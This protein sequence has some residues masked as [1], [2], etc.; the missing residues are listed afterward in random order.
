MAR[1]R[2]WAVPG[3]IA[4]RGGT[5]GPH[6]SS[7][8]DGAFCCVGGM[9][10]T[11]YEPV[12]PSVDLPALE[13]EVLAFWRDAGVFE[14]SL[15]AREGS[16]EWVFYEGPPTAN[17]KPGIH[18]AESRTFKDLYPQYRTMTGHYVAR[19]AGWDCHGLPVELEVERE[20]GTKTKRD[21]EAFGIEE[22][23]R[24]CRASVTRYVED[25]ERLTE[26]LGFW[27]DMSQAYFTMSPEYIESVWWS[28][29]ELHRQ[30]LLYEAHRSVAYCPRCGTALSDHE[31]ALG[32]STVV[33]PSVYVKLPI[34][35]SPNRPD[36]VGSSLVIWT[37]T[38]WTLPSNI[39][40][41]VAPDQTYVRAEVDGQGLVVAERLVGPSLGEDA[42][43][44]ETFPGS[45]LVGVRYE[46][47]YPN[48]DGDVHRVVTGDFVGMDE[49]TGIVHIATGFGSEDLEVGR[50]EGW[51]IYRPVDD[52]GKFTD[53]APE[54]VRGRAVKETDEDITG[55]LERSG[56]LLRAERYEHT[57]P[58]CW[59]C[60]TPLLYMAR[61]SWYIRTTAKKDRLLEVNE[62]VGWYPEHVKHG[63]YGDWLEN[64]VDW[65]LSRERY[66]GT[67]LPVWRCGNGHVTVIGSLAELSERAGR[68]VGAVDPHRPAIDEVEIPCPECGETARRVPEVIDTWY[69]SGAMPYA[70]W[71][72]H[73]DLNR[74]LDEARA[75][76]PA[77]FISEGIDQTRGWF[78]SLMAE[79]VLLFDDA[80]YRNC[81]VLGLLLDKEGRKMSKRLGNVVDPWEVLDRYGADALRWFFIVAGS[82][83]SD[84]RVSNEGI[85]DGVRRLLLTVW[86]VYA[87]YV[88]YANADDVDPATGDATDPP[89]LDRWILSRL[90]GTVAAARAGLD[91]YDATGAGR[92]IAGFVDDLSNWYVRLARRRFRGP[93][94]TPSSDAPSAH[95]TLYECLTT[96]CRLLA[97]FTPFIADAMWRNL[98]REGPESVHLADYP[99]A[100][101]VDRDER[102]EAAMESARRIVSLGRTVRTEAGVRVR[103]PLRR[104][105]VHAGGD[106]KVLE[107]LLGL[108]AEELNV[109][110]VSVVESAETLA[111]WRAIPNYRA[112]GP[113]LGKAVQEVARMLDGNEQAAAALARGERVELVTSSG[114]VEVGPEDVELERESVGGW[115]V[116]AEGGLTVGLDLEITPELARDGMARELVRF[117]QDARKAAGLD[118]A[119]RI[120]LGVTA[121]GPIA[122]AVDERAE[123]IAGEVLARR[124]VRGSL[125]GAEHRE[126]RTIDGHTAVVELRRAAG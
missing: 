27:I 2:E 40:A 69:D 65:A 17:G 35:E 14:K 80:A 6:A 44:G 33:D 90:A 103:Q 21:I 88:T 122:E 60:D 3:G 92:Q 68:D 110:E 111:G 1:D 108:V 107:P 117:I 114:E 74:G 125:D 49:G 18:H 59:R 52:D 24:R 78:Y 112:L 73:P 121:G 56:R 106:P 7:L 22:F 51:P 75:R 123:W 34:T 37:T 71:A 79:G 124:L 32:Y 54:F 55:D 70:Q 96:L 36:L 104:A 41:A 29:K 95:Q 72:Y 11:R 94:G 113:R 87:F 105:I 119:D 47:P 100:D 82:P 4:N 48:V 76:I 31:V 93:G 16:P 57:Y 28:L 43:R 10:V 23:N 101:D 63:R 81:V 26:R 46:P 118:I 9:S 77:D 99:Q 115:G 5:A 58:L 86:N 25:W 62:S 116:A 102:L 15:R 30:G 126:E 42:T 66:W 64:N 50:R 109:G 13:R 19:R 12:D 20:I 83:W 39:G 61:T 84:R 53:E 97:P 98:V 45:D 91:A 8:G 67:P 85:E 120:E 89:L 38:P